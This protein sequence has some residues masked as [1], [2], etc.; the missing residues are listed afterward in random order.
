MS[1]IIDEMP[2]LTQVQSASAHEI[3]LWQFYLRPT[4]S[5]DELGIVK[6]IARRYDAMSPATR[7]SIARRVRREHG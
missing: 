3:V 2:A 1:Y 6:A 7:E 4:L 5:N